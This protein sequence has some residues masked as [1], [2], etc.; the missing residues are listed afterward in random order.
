VTPS[1][2]I[3]HHLYYRIIH[4]QLLMNTKTGVAFN[5]IAVAAVKVLFTSGSLPAIQAQAFGGLH[6]GFGFHHFPFHHFHH[7]PFHHF[8]RF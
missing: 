7:F 1:N 5:I 6:H 3:R 8:G 4:K 2:G